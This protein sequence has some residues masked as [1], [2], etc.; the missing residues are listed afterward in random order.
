M[1]Q[2]GSG[3]VAVA[4]QPVYLETLR[5]ELLGQVSAVLAGDPGDEC[6]GHLR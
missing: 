4:H 6:D 2:L 3:R 5:R 1:Q